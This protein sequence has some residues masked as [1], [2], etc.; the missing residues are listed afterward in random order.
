MAIKDRP[1]KQNILFHSDR[2]VQ[3]ACTDFRKQLDDLP[4]L[5]S[6]SPKGNCWDNAITGSFFK[7]LKIELI[8][9][10]E[11]GTKQQAK[12]SIFEY[13]EVWYNRK[14]K[15]A[16]LGNRSPLQ[17]QSFLEDIRMAA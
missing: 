7:T 1:V 16:V 8:Y 15:H 4:V 14:R 9:H 2:G 17:Y 11:Y 5:Q 12:L 10:A 6:M 3:Y 13:I